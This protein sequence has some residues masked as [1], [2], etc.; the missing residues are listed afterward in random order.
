M[1]PGPL[2]MSTVGPKA[3]LVAF[4]APKAALVASNATKATLGRSGRSLRAAV[5][6]LEKSALPTG[7]RG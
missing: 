7:G 2:R 6:L 5:R 1:T 4:N 3:A